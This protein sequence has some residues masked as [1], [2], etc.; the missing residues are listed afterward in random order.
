MKRYT[1]L[2]VGLVAIFASA[3][4]LPI[5][6]AFAATVN[7]EIVPG[8]STKTT[9][10]FSPNPLEVN[11][12]DTVIW[13]NKDSA[14]HTVISGSD[15]TPDGKFGGTNE[16]PTLIPP[17]KTLEY[18]FTEAG[19]FPYFCNLHPAMVGTVTV[20]GEGGS[21]GGNGDGNG[22]AEEANEVETEIDGNTFTVMATSESPSLLEATVMPE[23]KMVGIEFEESGDVELTLPTDLISGISAVTTS[24][25]DDVEFQAGTS[26]AT[27]STISFTLPEDE[28]Y[29]DITG[30]TVAPEFG[31]I[32]ALVL[33]ASLVAAIGFARVKGSSL[34]FGRF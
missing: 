22:G 17:N 28:T 19:E 31:V 1:A 18:T 15:T 3:M 14:L 9:D 34:G 6:S 33:A 16:N 25:G 27:H 26:N 4:M 7:V 24:G 10:A 2:V 29:V 13:T 11:V 32:A 5:Q 12:G 30:A 8:A 23:E 20:A 21:D